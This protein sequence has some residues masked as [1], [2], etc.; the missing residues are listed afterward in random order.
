M[1]Y[2]AVTLILVGIIGC[3]NEQ[4]KS[5]EPISQTITTSKKIDEIRKRTRS[6]IEEYQRLKGG[7]Y[8]MDSIFNFERVKVYEISCRGEC[9]PRVLFTERTGREKVISKEEFKRLMGILNN[10]SSY[11]SNSAACYYPAIAVITYDKDE[12]PLNYIGICLDCNHYDTNIPDMRFEAKH[13]DGRPKYMGGYTRAARKAIRNFLY[14]I[15]F[16]YPPDGGY[17]WMFDDLEEI[18]QEMRDLG[19]DSVEIEERV[20]R[21]GYEFREEE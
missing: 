6:G 4:S 5:N 10:R 9:P 13:P 8:P 7:R 3:N 18:R 2:F 20:L 12:N 14:D 1:K 17:H 16:P 15:D 19:I 11:G 21:A